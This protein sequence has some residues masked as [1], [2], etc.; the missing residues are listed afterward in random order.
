M[1]WEARGKN[2]RPWLVAT[3]RD[4]RGDPDEISEVMPT[5][6]GAR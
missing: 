1:G 3:P 6:R 4:D 5:L 2:L